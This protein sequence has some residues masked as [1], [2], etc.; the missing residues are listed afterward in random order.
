MAM[1]DGKGMFIF[2]QDIERATEIIRLAKEMGWNE[3]ELQGAVNALYRKPAN[4]AEGQ[5]VVSRMLEKGKTARLVTA[6]D[7]QEVI[8]IIPEDGEVIVRNGYEVRFA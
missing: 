7:G 6:D 1:N 5:I 8:A 2:E 4:E 3:E